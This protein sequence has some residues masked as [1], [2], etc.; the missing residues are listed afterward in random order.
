MRLVGCWDRDSQGNTPP[1][2]VSIYKLFFICTASGSP[3][4]E[5]AETLG[6]AWFDPAELPPLSIT[7]VTDAQVQ[8]CAAHHRDPSLPAEFD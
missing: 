5:T 7:R 3:D 4:P 2:P 6:A 8:R 1:L